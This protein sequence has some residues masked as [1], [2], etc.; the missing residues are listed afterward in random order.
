VSHIGLGC[1]R[2]IA[3]RAPV[4]TPNLKEHNHA[5][6]AVP[7]R[8]MFWP[9]HWPLNTALHCSPLHSR[10]EAPPS[11]RQFNSLCA[12]QQ[13]L[14]VLAHVTLRQRY[15]NTSGSVAHCEYVLPVPPGA[16]VF[17]LVIT[18]GEKVIEAKVLGTAA[19]RHT[20]DTAVQRGDGAYLLE[21]SR[22]SSDVFKVRAAGPTANVTRL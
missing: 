13:L 14:D 19:A 10:T 8:A 16:A 7:E 1:T 9:S 18:I 3:G 17:R 21:Q 4:I 6:A 20:F 11:D 2:P 12:A 15:K 5:S 22:H